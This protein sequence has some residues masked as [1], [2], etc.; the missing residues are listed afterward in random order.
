MAN[1]D[2]SFYR[3]KRYELA[4]WTHTC[5]H[6]Y[7]CIN[8][9]HALLKFLAFCIEEAAKDDVD[10]CVFLGDYGFQLIHSNLLGKE[11][12]RSQDDIVRIE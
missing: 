11:D 8:S 4:G 3:V 6:I 2:K 9:H 10:S 7:N 12:L 5:I 1:D